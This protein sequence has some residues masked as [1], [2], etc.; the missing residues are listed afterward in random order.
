MSIRMKY[1]YYYGCSKLKN[2]I[3]EDPVLDHCCQHD[4]R[5]ILKDQ[6][7]RGEIT[8]E[9]YAQQRR[10]LIGTRREPPTFIKM[11]IHHGDFVVM[12]GEN[13]QKYYEVRH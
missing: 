2:L 3:A 1:K 11:S 12:H 9:A 13:L 8:E 10:A 4:K 5:A 6:R 7:M